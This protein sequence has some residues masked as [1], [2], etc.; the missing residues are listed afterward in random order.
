MKKLSKKKKEE[1][2]KKYGKIPSK[3][4]VF[5]K[6][7]ESQERLV[8]SL[9]KA[10]ETAPDNPQIRSELLE[11]MEK[12]LKLRSDLYKDIIKEEPPDLK[13][14]YDK[15]QEIVDDSSAN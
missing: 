8:Y 14:T 13:D 7:K 10:W 5:Q 12:A 9:A 4:E 15:L 6:L 1:I 11:A 3:E 2:I